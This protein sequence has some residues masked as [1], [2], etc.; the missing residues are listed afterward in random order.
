M[1]VVGCDSRV[2][3]PWVMRLV[4]GVL[5]AHGFTVQPVG[6]VPTPTVQ[7]A[8]LNRK[9]A[10]G[11]VVTASHNPEEWN[12]LKFVGHDSLFL[13]PAKW[14]SSRTFYSICSAY[15]FP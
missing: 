13:A 3:G 7:Y 14:D 5:L 6:I 9:A 1:I 4:E 15:D 11:V 8:V 10:G 12:G 2:S